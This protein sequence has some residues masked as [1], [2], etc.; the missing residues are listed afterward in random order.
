MLMEVNGDSPRGDYSGLRRHLGIC[1]RDTGWSRNSQPF[2]NRAIRSEIWAIFVPSANIAQ[3]G[4]LTGAVWINRFCLRLTIVHSKTTSDLLPPSWKLTVIDWGSLRLSESTQ[5]TC[6]TH[7]EQHGRTTSSLLPPRTIA[8]GI[9]CSS[10]A[11][12]E[13]VQKTSQ[14]VVIVALT[15]QS[16]HQ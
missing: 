12:L 5:E 7:G 11:Q 6:R 16:S 4:F 3:P 2:R 10:L 9:N 14:R 8:S 15:W 1:N 13:Y